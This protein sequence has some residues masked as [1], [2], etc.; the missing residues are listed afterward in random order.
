MES[1]RAL[2]PLAFRGASAPSSQA[3]RKPRAPPLTWAKGAASSEATAQGGPNERAWRARRAS[4]APDGDSLVTSRRPLLAKLQL[5]GAPGP[6]IRAP[7][8]ALS[9]ARN[10]SSPCKRT[11]AARGSTSTEG[12][13]EHALPTPLVTRAP[14]R[15]SRLLA[16]CRRTSGATRLP[17]L[18]AEPLPLA[19]HAAADRA[20]AATR[21]PA[22]KRM[23]PVQ[24][25]SSGAGPPL[26]APACSPARRRSSS[27]PYSPPVVPISTRRLPRWPV[28]ARAPSLLGGK[29]VQQA[30]APQAGA[31]DS[32]PACASLLAPLA[33]DG[34]R[35]IS[36]QYDVTLQ[37]Y[38]D[39]ETCKYYE[40]R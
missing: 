34:P 28:P 35:P 18:A 23:P 2:P 7:G 40:M 22:R 36:L 1:E 5:M 6:H 26:P 21:R 14:T 4:S 13:D 25:A 11:R 39:P 3:L 10:A 37:C 32:A 9:P 15:S 24:R 27:P 20:P 17:P 31:E 16:S 33:D 29:A 12:D 30:S 8:L 38:Y 19:A